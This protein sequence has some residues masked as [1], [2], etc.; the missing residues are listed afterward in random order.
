M[1][2]DGKKKVE[3]RFN[4][5]AALP[6]EE[7]RMEALTAPE[8]CEI[9][10]DYRPVTERP[11]SVGWHRPR[12]SQASEDL[13]EADT[14]FRNQAA[15]GGSFGKAANKEEVTSAMGEAATLDEDAEKARR[16]AR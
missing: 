6:T 3:L 16:Q 8:D 9:P 10:S 7:L 5:I 13:K 14:F 4:A 11:P 2:R 1:V 15:L 12:L